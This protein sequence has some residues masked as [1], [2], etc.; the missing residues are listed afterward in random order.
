MFPDSILTTF[1]RLEPGQPPVSAA[2]DVAVIVILD[3]VDEMHPHVTSPAPLLGRRVLVRCDS[4]P[5]RLNVGLS[6][7]DENSYQRIEMKRFVTES[8]SSARHRVPVSRV[9]VGNIERYPWKKAWIPEFHMVRPRS[10]SGAALP[11]SH[12]SCAGRGFLSGP[13]TSLLITQSSCSSLSLS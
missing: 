2:S 4:R 3:R 1:V 6:D 5:T 11:N 13:S 12:K 7:S 9:K 8:R 10:R